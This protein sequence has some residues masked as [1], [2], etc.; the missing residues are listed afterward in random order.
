MRGITENELGL[1]GV[2]A[3]T[4]D[5]G[6][7][8][9]AGTSDLGLRT[10][11]GGTQFDRGSRDSA[12]PS[13][14]T[15]SPAKPVTPPP[16]AQRVAVAPQ[17]PTGPSYPPIPKINID[18]ET[19]RNPSYN[20][21]FACLRS[22]DPVAAVP[23]FEAALRER[24]GDPLV[25]NA[26]L[27]AQD[28]VK[29]HQ[30]PASD[31]AT[32][33]AQL[34]GTAYRGLL[35]GDTAL[36]LRAAR[37]GMELNPA[38]RRFQG[39]AAMAESLAPASAPGATPARNTAARLVAHS[40]LAVESERH[41]AAVGLLEAADALSPN[42]PLIA[43]MLPVARKAQVKKPEPP[44]DAVKSF[45]FP[46]HHNPDVEEF[47]FPGKSRNQEQVEQVLF[48]KKTANQEQVEK[49]LFPEKKP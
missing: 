35:T 12:P 22:Y 49:L 37:R 45:L 1:K 24:P 11:G 36:A 47:L 3:T 8:G 9:V 10:A 33:S 41:A 28:L 26:L 32:R 31:A 14:R 20:Q 4:P 44:V 43:Q 21:G 46:E 16:N 2:D 25:I 13:L 30:Q 19:L 18:P 39:L 15:P 5:L 38:D 7:R 6:L 42:D 40:L 34:T 48:P 27:L 23:C 17:P 29:V